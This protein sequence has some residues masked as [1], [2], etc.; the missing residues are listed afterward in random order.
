MIETIERQN[1]IL[2]PDN[3]RVS[4]KTIGFSKKLNGFYSQMKLYCTHFNFC[5]EYEGLL[6]ID[7]KGIIF[8]VTPSQECGITRKKMDFN[9][10]IELQTFKNINRLMREHPYLGTMEI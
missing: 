7:E 8:K 10:V 1:L 2:R 5:S 4:R 6:K 9:I 3:K